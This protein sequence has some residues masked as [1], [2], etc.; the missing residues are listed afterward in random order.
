[1]PFQRRIIPTATSANKLGTQS[2]GFLKKID[3]IRH[4]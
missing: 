2:G 3:I 1:M 4:S